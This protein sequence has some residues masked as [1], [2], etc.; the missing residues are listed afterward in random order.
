MFDRFSLLA[1][2]GAYPQ[3]D[4]KTKSFRM[5]FAEAFKRG[6]SSVFLRGGHC[7]RRFGRDIEC[8]ANHVMAGFAMSEVSVFVSPICAFFNRVCFARLIWDWRLP[9]RQ[10]IIIRFCGTARST[11]RIGNSAVLSKFGADF[12]GSETPACWDRRERRGVADNLRRGGREPEVSYLD[13]PQRKTPRLR[14][15]FPA[16]FNCNENLPS[17]V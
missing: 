15:G 6:C 10:V 17:V 4:R 16:F 8:A 13:F 2:S 9:W 5:G 3:A 1:E 11:G 14:R 12:T 7:R